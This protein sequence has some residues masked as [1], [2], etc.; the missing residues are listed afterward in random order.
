MI[1]ATIPLSLGA[2]SYPVYVGQNIFATPAILAPH[3]HGK[4]I[5]IVTQEKLAVHYLPQLQAALS[6]YQLD[7]FM[8]PDGEQYKNLEQWQYVLDALL[9]AGHERSTTLIALGGG[10]VGDITGFAAA[11]YLRGVNYIQ[12]PTTLIAQIDAAIGG[13]TG[14]NHPQGKN[15]IGAFHQPQCVVVDVDLLQTL[16]KREYIAGLAEMI[17]YG[18]ICDAD[19]FSWLE[20]N[21]EA[22]L[23]RQTDVLLRAIRV[24]AT[25]KA[26]I[27]SEDACDRGRR[28]LLNFGHTFG[29]AL[30]ALGNYQQFLHGEAV[31]IGMAM[32]TLLS[33]N[34]GLITQT[35][36]RRVICF[37]EAVGFQLKEQLSS[38]T[39]LMQLMRRDKKVQDGAFNFILL[40]ALGH[41]EKNATVSDVQLEKMLQEFLRIQ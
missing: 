11:C 38:T 33:G 17:K 26:C 25:I 10:V 2:H 22:L 41:A 7:V 32:A 37:L 16:P 15:M 34:L 40:T 31:A 39:Q 13:K 3:I 19:F 12:I 20:V 36:V 28:N 8:L 1:H 29:H 35:D 14:V 18:L 24:C 4:Q 21:R 23:A 27:V 9:Q 6:G 30:E 5:L